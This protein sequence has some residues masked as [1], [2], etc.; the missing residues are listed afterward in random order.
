MTVPGNVNELL[1]RTAAAAGGYS[2]DRSLRFNSA[3]GAN[4][5]RSFSAGDQKT[6]TWSAWVK[7]CALSGDQ[8]LFGATG[9]TASFIRFKGTALDFVINGVTHRR[10]TALFRDPSAWYHFLWAVDTTQGTGSNRSRFYVNG[11]EVTTWDTNT[12]LTQNSDTFINSANTHLIGATDTVP[13]DKLSA[14][15]ADIYFIGGS[16]L[17]PSS[18][19]ETD[20][21]TGVWVPKTPTGLTY[22]TNGFRLTFSDNSGTT[23]TTLGKDAAGSNNWTP[24]NFSVTAG[25]GND[26]LRDSPTNGTASTGGDAGGVTVGNYATLNPLA[27]PSGATLSNGNLDLSSSAAQNG[28]TAGTIYVNSGKWY[29][30]VTDTS[31]ANAL[32]IGITKNTDNLASSPGTT[33]GGYYYIDIGSAYT[34]NNNNLVSYGATWAVNDVIGVALDMDGGTLTFYKNGTSQGTAFTGLSGYFAPSI[35]DGGSSTAA[36]CTC[37]FGQRAFAYAAPS[38]YK[39]LCTANL[40]APTIVKPSSVMDVVLYTGTGSTLTPTSALGFNPDLVWIKSRSAATDNTLYDAVR[41]AQARLESN[42]TDVEVTSDN[43]LT[44]FNSNG[45][46]LGTL[47]QVN[48]NAATYAGWCFD[49]GTSNATN[50]SGTITSTVRANISAGF[51]IVT[52]TGTGSNAAVGHGLGVA[53]QLVIVKRRS[54]AGGWAT[55]HTSIANTNYLLLNS[56]AASTSGTT[57]WNSTSPT[58]SVFSIGTSADVNASSSTYVAYCFA[59]V[60][61]YSAFGSYSGTGTTD[62]SFVYTGFR[63]AVVIVKRSNGAADWIIQDNKRPGYNTNTLYLKPNSS[64][65]EIDSTG[66]TNKNYIDFV[67]NGFKLRGTDTNTN[68]AQAYIYA[69]WAESPFGLNNRAR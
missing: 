62:G 21:T 41:G 47:A 26:S 44:A 50:T 35:G 57:Y 48:T 8:G 2:I 22:G 25:A 52:Y 34:Y 14:Y 16:Q 12:T 55:W 33:A 53:P 19:G 7:P 29:W 27:N 5:S 60:A 24:N 67:S 66:E 4:L 11:V 43:G 28:A 37:N 46:T 6:W 17:T 36:A 40:P 1:L 13:N 31:G 69:A 23:A 38:G 61:G 30:E 20:A 58:S 54:A 39:A 32:Y 64:S 18:F 49:A 42:N 15:L 51:S 3:D 45:F 68:A 63:P 65:E 9:S 59:P 10:T 56:T